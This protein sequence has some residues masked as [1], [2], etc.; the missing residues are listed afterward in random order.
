LYFSKGKR[1]LLKFML[2]FKPIIRIAR[3]QDKLWVQSSDGFG[4]EFSCAGLVSHLWFW[5][6]KFILKIQNFSIFCTSDQKN[7]IGMG[8]KVPRFFKDSGWPLIYCG[9]IVSGQGP[10]LAQSPTMPII[11]QPQITKNISKSP[12]RQDSGNLHS[13]S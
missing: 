10:S 5:F 4:S 1:S 9:S 11:F 8:Q 12:P 2:I 7:I 13:D 3:N 6:G